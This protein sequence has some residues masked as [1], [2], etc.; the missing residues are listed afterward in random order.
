[1]LCNLTI[2]FCPADDKIKKLEEDLKQKSDLARRYR[3]MCAR[4][5]V[6]QKS[7]PHSRGPTEDDPKGEIAKVCYDFFSQILRGTMPL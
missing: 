6:Q 7:R 5:G 1:M 4:N 3:D 2:L